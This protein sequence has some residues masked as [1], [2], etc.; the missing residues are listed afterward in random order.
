MANNQENIVFLTKV[1]IV[2]NKLY[3]C[4]L[5]N[6]VTGQIVTIST[7]LEFEDTTNLALPANKDFP[8]RNLQNQFIN[9]DNITEEDTYN[10]WIFSGDNKSP[11]FSKYTLLNQTSNIQDNLIFLS[12]VNFKNNVLLPCI[13][14]NQSTGEKITITNPIEFDDVTNLAL[15]SFVDRTLGEITKDSFV[16]LTTIND[17]VQYKFWIFNGT[18]KSPE[19]SLF[20]GG[21]GGSQPPTTL[22]KYSNSNPMPSKVGGWNKGSTFNEVP[23]TE[24]WTGLLYE[25]QNPQITQFSVNPN[26][27]EIG[28]EL[29]T[30]I[31]SSWKVSNQQNAT[32]LEFYFDGTKL[33]DKLEYSANNKQIT[34]TP[35][36]LTQVGSKRCELKLYDTKGGTASRSVNINWNNFMY[37]GILM[38]D[39]VE[40]SDLQSLNKKIT[41]SPLGEFSF[42]MEGWKFII[43]PAIYSHTRIEDK[44]TKQ[45]VDITQLS[46]I[47]ITNDYNVTQEFK[48]FRSTYKLN[49]SIDMIIS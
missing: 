22:P 34:I 23:L 15:E 21:S 4:V 39:S 37:Y 46:N 9:L 3:P 6:T 28:Q 19:M 49:G 48:V 31:T 42:E 43:Y 27:L 17:L 36:R 8:F 16:N 26:S 14:Y 2:D 11:E 24:M 12:K 44:N 38:K 1:K 40:V 41:N 47:S 5:Y 32:N 29:S 20:G 35:Q 13:L 10:Y 45:Q 30:P 25:F 18:Y 33:L 7:I